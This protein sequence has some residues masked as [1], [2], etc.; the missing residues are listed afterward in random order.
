MSAFVHLLHFILL[1]FLSTPLVVGTKS[2]ASPTRHSIAETASAILS[3]NVI[4]KNKNKVMLNL[5]HD[6]LNN[7]NNTN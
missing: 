5:N 3:Q 7:N 2:S 4:P 1:C 6:K